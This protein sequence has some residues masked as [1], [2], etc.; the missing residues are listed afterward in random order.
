MMSSE[1]DWTI[2]SAQY[3]WLKRD[4][5]NVNRSATP[6]V[7]LT[8]HRMMYT[9]Q[10]KEQGD[11]FV[12]ELMKAN[13]DALLNGVVDSRAYVNL[14]LVGHQHSYER[15]CP[16]YAGQCRANGK[17]TVHVCIGTAGAS[18]ETHGFSTK[19]GNYS[20]AHNEVD[21]GLLRLTATLRSLRFEFVENSLRI[22]DSFTLNLWN[23]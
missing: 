20:V 17:A 11:Y 8:S 6:W 14:M 19:F 2:G 12:S 22:Y 10:K 3:E 13:L 9:T 23:K 16:V 7:V 4:L 5:L 15:S 18:L 21:W 1:H